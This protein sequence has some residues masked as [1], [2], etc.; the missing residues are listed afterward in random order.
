MFETLSLRSLYGSVKRH[1]GRPLR[2]FLPSLRTTLLCT[3]GI[4]V[5][6]LLLI[7]YVDRPLALR[8]QTVAPGI[9][10]FFF[11]VTQL[12]KST[13]Y[14]T[15]FGLV[16][17]FFYPASKT[18]RYA[19][20]AP[21]LRRFALISL[22]IFLAV[23]LSGI[24]TD[25][26]KVVFARYRPVMLYRKGLFGFVFFRFSPANV[27]S[28]PSGHADT[29][30]SLSTALFL[31]YPRYRG[32]YILLA[33]MVMASRLIVGEHFLSDVVAGAYLGI[34]TTYYLKG[35]FEYHRLSIFPKPRR[36]PI[37]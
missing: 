13:P 37:K 22:F 3:L 32:L 5:L 34:V 30:A 1:Q 23:A 25:L 10:R 19:H 27:L 15:F 14:L 36:Q 28:F 29:I 4:G 2:P 9:E 16:F 6:C 8:L 18:E 20:K 33:L 21:A 31:L 35:F 17:I 24:L 7:L 11:Y 12:G 26:L